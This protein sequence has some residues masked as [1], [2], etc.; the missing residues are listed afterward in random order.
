MILPQ[1]SYSKESFPSRLFQREYFQEDHF[2]GKQFP[3]EIIR[4]KLFQRR[5]LEEKSPKEHFPNEAVRRKL[6]QRY[7]SIGAQRLTYCESIC[8]YIIIYID[9]FGSKMCGFTSHRIDLPPWN[10]LPTVKLPPH[11]ETASLNVKLPSQRENSAPL[12]RL[13]S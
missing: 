7:S 6:F 4:R 3:K 8:V 10:S 11:R 13:I 5:L 12:S 2:R 9:I 1:G